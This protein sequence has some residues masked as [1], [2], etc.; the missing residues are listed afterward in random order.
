LRVAVT[1]LGG[2]VTLRAVAAALGGPIRI[3]NGMQ[4]VREARR[5][6]QRARCFTLFHT[7]SELNCFPFGE[8]GKMVER[9]EWCPSAKL[10]TGEGKLMP[11][12]R[13]RVSDTALE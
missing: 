1:Q 4:T 8:T 10:W 9:S 3:T 13:A 11:K 5:A 2:P 6:M 12:S 7:A